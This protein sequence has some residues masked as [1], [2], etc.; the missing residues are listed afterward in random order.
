MPL[1]LHPAS[2]HCLAKKQD[3][4]ALR[5][6]RTIRAFSANMA[7]P[8]VPKDTLY[9]P[10]NDRGFL[11]PHLPA[12]DGSSLQPDRVFATLTFATSLD[13]ELALSPGAPT[14]LSGPQSKAMTHYLRSQHDAIMI[15]VGT[16]VADDPSLNCRLFGVGGYGGERLQGQPRPIVIDPTARWDFSEK[17]KIFILCREGRGRAPYIVTGVEDPPKEKKELLESYGGKFIVLPIHTSDIGQHR[18]D[19]GQLLE[20]LKRADLTSVMIEGGG[21]VIN[22][23]LELQYQKFIDS[24]II[25]IAPTW[26]GQ[27]GVV[28][29]P[30][31][32]FNGEHKAIPA[33][34]LIN[35]KWQP[36][37][38]DVVLCGRVKL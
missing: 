13:S 19:W 9:L 24:V 34:R 31:R 20:A 22:S 2:L 16:A 4:A 12:K 11:E 25:T 3:I 37:G 8:E 18:L 15:G 6:G 5:I 7:S 23:L 26:L 1:R 30:R 36:F 21:A 10:E 17:N 38:E 35:V 29:S 32:R 28:V 27:G 14:A 33:G